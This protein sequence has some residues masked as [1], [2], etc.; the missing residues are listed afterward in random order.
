MQGH[1]GGTAW[2][3]WQV[4]NNSG[5]TPQ[6]Y[7]V[8]TPSILGTAA[9]AAPGSAATAIGR[10]M[11]LQFTSATTANAQ[12][13]WHSGAYWAIASS[14]AGAGMWE[15]T[16]RFGPSQLP[17]GPRLFVGGKGVSPSGLTTEPS[18]W[19][20]HL[21]GFA[22]DSTDTNIQLLVNSNASGGTKTDTGIPLTAGGVYE[23][24]VWAEPGSLTIYGLL[25]R[26]DTGAI[27]YGS[28]ST[29]VPTTNQGL[30]PQCLG[31]LSGT[32]G[33]AMILHIMHMFGRHG[34]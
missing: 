26:L 19:T 22:K 20:D 31:G 7:G 29:D 3:G 2:R 18:A 6:L 30:A 34:F 9:A 25:I 32:T 13:G 28:T 14:T 21:A 10:L 1:I 33:T 4:I 11:R 17:T 5:T 8:T 12:C 23:A 15:M 27:W 16:A 24:S